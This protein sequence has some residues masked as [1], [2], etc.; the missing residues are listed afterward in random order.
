VAGGGDG[1]SDGAKT[2]ERWFSDRLHREITLVRWGTY[3]APVLVFPTA[4]GDAAEIE[5]F[6]LV[7]GYPGSMN[8]LYRYITQG[9]VEADRP[10]LSPKR[11]T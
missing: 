5:R 2:A 3:G 1:V 9:R 10:H 4:G 7:D 6:G 8:L 11:G